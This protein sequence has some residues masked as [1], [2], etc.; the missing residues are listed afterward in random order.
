MIDSDKIQAALDVVRSMDGET[1]AAFRRNIVRAVALQARASATV[2]YM[3]AD[4]A[5]LLG[6]V[7]FMIA[8]GTESGSP[9]VPNDIRIAVDSHHVPG[10]N[11]TANRPIDAMVG[12]MVDAMACILKIISQGKNAMVIEVGSDANMGA[13]AQPHPASDGGN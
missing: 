8:A 4:S 13:A 6:A 7:V 10:A 12:Q 11:E 5:D 1:F 9:N 2:A 3:L